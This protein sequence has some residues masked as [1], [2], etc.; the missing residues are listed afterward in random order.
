[1]NRMNRKTLYIIGGAAAAVLIAVI[2]LFIALGGNS[3][4]KYA[5]HY[6]AAEAAFLQKN[7][8]RALQE[9]DKAMDIDA[10]EEAYLLMADVYYAQ[11]DLD[12]AMQVLYLGQ[13]HVGGNAISDM[14]TRLKTENA[15]N[16]ESAPSKDVMVGGKLFT[17]ETTSAVL[18]GK[19]LGNEDVKALGTL[20]ALEELTLSGNDISDISPLSELKWLTSLQLADNAVSDLSPLSGLYALKTLYIDG[21]PVTDF[22]ALEGLSALRT[23]SMKNITITDTQLESL[24]RALPNCSIYSDEPV[25]VIPE[26]SIGGRTVRVDVTELNLSGLE[27]DDISPLAQCTAL[28]K[29]DLRD[30]KI[31]D[32]SPLAECTELEWLCL[33]NNQVEDLTPLAGLTGL[34]YLDVD[35]NA[36]GSIVALEGLTELEEL[37]LSNNPFSVVE[38]LHGMTKLTRLSLKNV[39]LTDDAFD[40]LALFPALK[41][42]SI[43]E[44]EGLSQEKFDALQEA[45]PNCTIAHGELVAEEA[46]EDE[47]EEPDVAPD[48]TFVAFGSDAALQAA[49]TGTG[50]A[51]IWD[52]TD[53]ASAG[54]RKGFLDQAKLLGMN[55]VADLWYEDIAT[56]APTLAVGLRTL[57]A[58]TVFVAAGDDTM[59]TL[60]EQ[61]KA[62]D[63]APNFIQV[64]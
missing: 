40:V 42:L 28:K 57:G 20:T 52:G 11:G 36:I 1:M 29:L 51:V 6:D 16:P 54:F 60:L 4:K 13:S 33:W 48:K 17:P 63:Y 27:L 35:M 56:E 38:P 3:G 46:P 9:L 2:V 62:I 21:N 26:I 45:L 61:A 43:E 25:T 15:A 58:D 53:A 12:M 64:F 24:H 31:S 50:Y 30:N 8:G 32:L 18:A 59:E 22:S 10:T 23:L 34:R 14:L 7:Y 39:G 47:R 37:W 55:V 41:E 44:N 5:E 19:G 49:G